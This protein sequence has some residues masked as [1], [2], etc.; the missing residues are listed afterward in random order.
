MDWSTNHVISKT[1]FF[2]FCLNVFTTAHYSSLFKCFYYYPIV[3]DVVEVNVQLW[4]VK[5]PEL[6]PS[7][8]IVNFIHQEMLSFDAFLCGFTV[9]I[10]KAGSPAE[11]QAVYVLSM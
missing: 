3:L 9:V 11:M 1:S 5:S 8:D 2:F 6:I 7:S 10:N 4:E